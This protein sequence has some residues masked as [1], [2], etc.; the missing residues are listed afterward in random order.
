MTLSGRGSLPLMNYLQVD[1][2]LTN[3]LV[4]IIISQA[5]AACAVIDVGPGKEASDAKIRGNSSISL[6]TLSI[7][8]D[9]VNRRIP[10]TLFQKRTMRDDRPRRIS[11]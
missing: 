4:R 8:A 1:C 3:W 6:I 11:R 2:F 5:D 7:D 10:E 9:I